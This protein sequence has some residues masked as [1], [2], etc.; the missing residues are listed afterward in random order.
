MFV[1]LG[2]CQYVPLDLWRELPCYVQSDIGAIDYFAGDSDDQSGDEDW[3]GFFSLIL[4]GI[5]T[6]LAMVAI[7]IL[8]VLL[9]LLQCIGSGRFSP[10][11]G[12]FDASLYLLCLA[13]PLA[14]I[15]G[16]VKWSAILTVVWPPNLPYTRVAKYL[17]R[18][19][20]GLA[21]LDFFTRQLHP[22]S[23]AV[24]KWQH[25]R[26]TTHLPHS[27]MDIVAEYLRGGDEDCPLVLATEMCSALD[28]T[29][30]LELHSHEESSSSS[31][32]EP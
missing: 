25:T 18:A 24:L 29:N 22:R 3:S 31:R 21:L 20:I 27:V 16:L 17:S 5:F 4:F 1:I 9:G 14:L 8:A 6:F 32:I 13:I 11:S 15:G 7:V 19:I 28:S 2:L 30:V 12:I 26:L 10:R 23:L